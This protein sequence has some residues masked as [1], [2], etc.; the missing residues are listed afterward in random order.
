ME[1]PDYNARRRLKK[2]MLD[3]WENEGG[4]IAAD[5][6]VAHESNPASNRESEGNQPAAS[7]ANATVGTPTAPAKK[8]K[9]TLKCR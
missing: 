7:R 3:R 4:R 1:M 9:R 5:S 2:K 6:A 8:R